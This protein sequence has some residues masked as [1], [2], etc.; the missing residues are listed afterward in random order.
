MYIK[1]SVHTLF[2]NSGDYIINCLQNYVVNLQ[3]EHV[4]DNQIYQVIDEF[5]YYTDGKGPPAAI[6]IHWCYIRPLFRGISNNHS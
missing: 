2:P 4:T 3:R 6:S 1:H 5:K